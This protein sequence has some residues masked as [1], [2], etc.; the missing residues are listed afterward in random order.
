MRTAHRISLL[1]ILT[2]ILHQIRWLIRNPTA[3]TFF[4]LENWFILICMALCVA[5]FIMLKEK[6]E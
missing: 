4:V 6:N 3:E 1:G 5:V 2:C